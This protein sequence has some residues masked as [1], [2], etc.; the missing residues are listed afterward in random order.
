MGIERPWTVSD[1]ELSLE[2]GEVK[3][4]V[5]QETGMQQCC[6]HCATS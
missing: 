2:A 4:H 5:E 1:I 6:P 3:G